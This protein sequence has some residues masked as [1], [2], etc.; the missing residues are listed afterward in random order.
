[1]KN[2]HL[3]VMGIGHIKLFLIFRKS[4]LQTKKSSPPMN[5]G[6]DFK[7]RYRIKETK[8]HRMK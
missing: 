4:F 6:K 2:L 5:R 7:S 3:K 1:M 8:K